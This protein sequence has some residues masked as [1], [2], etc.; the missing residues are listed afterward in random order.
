MEETPAPS[1]CPQP[2]LL[3]LPCCWG[4]EP[5]ATFRLSG[6][7]QRIRRKKKKETLNFNLKD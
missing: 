7:C 6:S 5:L 3:M 2:A 4:P 1:C